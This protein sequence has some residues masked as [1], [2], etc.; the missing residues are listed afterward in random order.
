ML[1]IDKTAEQ[2]R[3]IVTI[4][5]NVTDDSQGFNMILKSPSTLKT[6]NIDLPENTST[7]KNRFDEFLLDTSIFNDM[8][9]GQYVYFIYQKAGNKILETGLLEISD[10][11]KV[12]VFISI[13]QD[14]ADDD[15]IFYTGQ[16]TTNMNDDTY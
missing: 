10:A 16:N 9:E 2:N 5:E 3:I 11:T 14:E 1:Q 6:F 4:S 12:D 13:E 7:H 15:I 8:I